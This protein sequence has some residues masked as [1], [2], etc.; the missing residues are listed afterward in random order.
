VYT[1]AGCIYLIGGTTTTTTAG[2]Q[3]VHLRFDPAAGANGQW[4]TLAAYA[5]A[6]SSMGAGYMDGSP[7]YFGGRIS[8]GAGQGTNDMYL[9]ASNTY[10]AQTETAIQARAGAAYATHSSFSG[11]YVFIV[12]GAPTFAAA[13]AYFSPGLTG[14]TYVAQAQSLQ[15][16]T[17][18]ATGG[19]ATNGRPHPAFAGGNT[20]IVFAS[21]A[22][23]PYN[24]TSSVDPTLYVFG[25]IRTGLMVTNEVWAMDADET[26]G[27]YSP[28]GLA[29]VSKS[30]MPRERYGHGVTRVNP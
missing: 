7:C 28:T 23:S 15:I 25:G 24:G 9:I 10:T 13:T 29:W 3:T 12:G 6:R 11:T 30:S 18:P 1:H 14:I 2:V 27:S 20:G 22:V 8:T 16:Y 26:L 17:P 19:A 5:T 21:A 4:T